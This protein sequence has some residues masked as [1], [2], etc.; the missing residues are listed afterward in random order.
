MDPLYREQPA[1]TA[2][3]ARKEGVSLYYEMRG[4][5]DAP[6]LVVFLNGGVCTL[7]HFD[8]AWTRAQFLDVQ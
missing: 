1:S 4:R 8:E 7:R 3:F 6:A 2:I 5:E